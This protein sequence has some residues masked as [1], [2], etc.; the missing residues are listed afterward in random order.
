MPATTE[1]PE[2]F[3]LTK[4]YLDCVAPDG[5]AAI[6]YWASLRLH[7]LEIGWNNVSTYEPGQPPRERTSLHLVRAPQRSGDTITWTSHA[8]GCTF[9]LDATLPPATIQLLDDPRGRIDWRCEAPAARVRVTTPDGAPLDGTGYAEC[10]VMTVLPWQ[11]PLDQLRWGRW[12]SLD[13]RRS[14]V[15]IDWRGEK[16]SR[17]A[18]VD[19]V[20]RTDVVVRDSDIAFSGATLPLEP[21]R[22]LHDRRLGDI[23][24]PIKPLAAL[25]PDALLALHEQKRCGAAAL[26]DG[27]EAPVSGWTIH[28]LVQLR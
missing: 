3:A 18:L 14:L 21:S 10:L 23:V 17:W 1:T 2:R 22:T 28:E 27:T 7:G 16:P 20:V 25:L 5:R 11:L 13:A 4:W 8:L 26:H 24:G 6:G 12:V 9:T 15:W 19:G